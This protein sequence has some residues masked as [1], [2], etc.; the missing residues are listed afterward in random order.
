MC[1][2]KCPLKFLKLIIVEGGSATRYQLIRN[3]FQIKFYNFSYRYLRCLRFI[4]LLWASTKVTE[5]KLKKTSKRQKHM[6]TNV[7]RDKG[8]VLT[9]RLLMLAFFPQHFPL[10]KSH[11]K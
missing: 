8:N 4:F 1:L 9:L 11:R 3:K 5:W 10:S 6:K 7:N 2:K